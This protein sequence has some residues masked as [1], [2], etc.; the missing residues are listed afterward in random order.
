MRL[1]ELTNNIRRKINKTVEKKKT[2]NEVYDKD[3]E[4]IKIDEDDSSVEGSSSS[5][6]SSRRESNF[7][8][9]QMP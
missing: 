3:I 5:D 8:K 2:S 9:K 1:N 7:N 4:S 6:S